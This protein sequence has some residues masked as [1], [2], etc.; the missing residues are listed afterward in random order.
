MHIIKS[1]S[2]VDF[3]RTHTVKDPETY[4]SHPDNISPYYQCA[5]AVYVKKSGPPPILLEQGNM[6]LILLADNTAR[7]QKPVVNAYLYQVETYDDYLWKL[8]LQLFTVEPD[9]EAAMYKYAS[10]QIP[11]KTTNQP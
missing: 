5:D 6:V 9:E 4:T 2:A 3:L 11:K 1:K 8:S 7:S 10:S